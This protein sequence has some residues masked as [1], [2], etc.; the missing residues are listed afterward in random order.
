MGCGRRLHGQ[1]NGCADERGFGLIEATVPAG[2]GPPAHAHTEQEETFY[3]LD[4]ELEFLDGDHIFTAVAGDFVHIPR[5]IRHRFTNKGNHAAKMI[6]MFTW[7]LRGCPGLQ[8][9]EESDS[10]G[11]G[12]ATE[13][14]LQG[15]R[16][17]TRPGKLLG[18]RCENQARTPC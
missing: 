4:G 16:P 15:E 11:A 14:R 6:F 8:A 1:G 5:G 3:I 12:Q 7:F 13:F 17:S 2:G 18:V 9:G 10:C